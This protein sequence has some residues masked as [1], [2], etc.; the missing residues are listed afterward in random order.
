MSNNTLKISKK[1]FIYLISPNKIHN[2]FYNNLKLVLK[3]KKVSFFHALRI[4]QIAVRILSDM[5]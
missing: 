4:R 1:K 2:S 3:T 5:N